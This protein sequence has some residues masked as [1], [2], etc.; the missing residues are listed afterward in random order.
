MNRKKVIS[1]T[2]L[3]TILLAGVGYYTIH[4][5][6]QNAKEYEAKELAKEL[7]EKQIEKKLTKLEAL[8]QQQGLAEAKE[9]E[10]EEWAADYEGMDVKT[11]LNETSSEQAVM[12]VMHKMTHQKVRAQEKWGAIPMSPQIINEVHH[13]I[14][15]STFENKDTMLEMT[16]AWKNRDFSSIVKHHNFFWKLHEGTV[17]K[18]YGTLSEAEETEFINN[19]FK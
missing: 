14:N 15:K 11:G 12:A 17:G 18:A 7:D 10:M 3:S 16:T 9:R 4:G 1:I 13:I 8:T 5:I 19:H 2:A 6:T